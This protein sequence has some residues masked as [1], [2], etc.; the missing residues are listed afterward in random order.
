MMIMIMIM[1]SIILLGD[2][3]STMKVNLWILQSERD[4]R[5]DLWDLLIFWS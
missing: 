5:A 3:N 4:Y 2:T 1:I